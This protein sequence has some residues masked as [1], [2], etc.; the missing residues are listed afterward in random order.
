[1]PEPFGSK[2]LPSFG[3]CDLASLADRANLLKGSSEQKGL[4]GVSDTS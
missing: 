1:M 4:R 2:F 3:F